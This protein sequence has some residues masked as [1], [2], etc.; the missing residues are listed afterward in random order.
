MRFWVS[1]LGVPNLWGS[2]PLSCSPL[3]TSGDGVPALEH[4]SCTAERCDT[5]GSFPHGTLPSRWVFD[6]LGPIGEYVLPVM[7]WGFFAGTFIVDST[8]VSEQREEFLSCGAEVWG[9][10]IGRLAYLGLGSL[11]LF[12][13]A[14]RPTFRM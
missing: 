10:D 11:S 12:I 14:I 5:F 1:E 9:K 2:F 6:T 8:I 7:W 13:L 4:R 3:H